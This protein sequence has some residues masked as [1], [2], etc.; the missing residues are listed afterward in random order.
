M[1]TSKAKAFKKGIQENGA[2]K[3][4]NKSYSI[5]KGNVTWELFTPGKELDTTEDP[6]NNHS[7]W[8]QV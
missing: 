6:Q 8:D 1:K 2:K 4:R 7:I 3:V 5:G